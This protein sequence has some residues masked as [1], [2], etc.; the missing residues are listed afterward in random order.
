MSAFVALSQTNCSNF[1]KKPSAKASPFSDDSLEALRV[2][3]ASRLPMPGQA[4]FSA[5]GQPFYLEFSQAMEI[6]G[7]V[8][9]GDTF[10]SGV[11]VGYKEQVQCAY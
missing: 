8:G 11:P 7:V 10:S 9:P 4:V 3:M 5:D 6:I 1:P 2:K